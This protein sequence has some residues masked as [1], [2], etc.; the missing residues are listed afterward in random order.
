MFVRHSEGGR[1]NKK[2]QKRNREKCATHQ[3]ITERPADNER[4]ANTFHFL[5]FF[6]SAAVLIDSD[7]YPPVAATCLL[8]Q[9]FRKRNNSVERRRR[10]QNPSQLGGANN[11]ETLP[12]PKKKPKRISKSSYLRIIITARF[13]RLS[14][15]SAGNEKKYLFIK[16]NTKR[17]NRLPPSVFTVVP[18]CG[19]LSFSSIRFV[20]PYQVVGYGTHRGSSTCCF[21]PWWGINQQGNS[22]FCF[23]FLK[24]FNV[25]NRVFGRVSKQL[26]SLFHWFFSHMWTSPLAPK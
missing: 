25:L 3:S 6:F 15:W 13:R 26:D 8:P 11:A 14:T 19:S 21:L 18:L 22:K 1:K 9:Q 20:F 2:K 23:P 7:R 16:K 12:P 5:F 4:P 17:K 24:L 10:R